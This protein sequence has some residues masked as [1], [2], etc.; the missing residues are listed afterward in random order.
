[1]GVQIGVHN[2]APCFVGKGRAV[3][4]DFMEGVNMESGLK[5]SCRLPVVQVGRGD[6]SK[7]QLEQK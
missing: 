6:E 4:G 7:G 3:A 2:I 1:M 5:V